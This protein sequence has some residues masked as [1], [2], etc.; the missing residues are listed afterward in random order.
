MQSGT[1]LLRQVHPQWIKDGRILSLAFR[2]F[3]K[4]EGLL[5]VYDGDRITARDSWLHFTQGQGFNSAGVWAVSVAESEACDLSSRPD[6]LPGNPDHAVIDFTAHARK[7]QEAKSKI[8]SAR[9]QERGCL[10]GP[11]GQGA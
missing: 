6:P 3:P 8:L 7:Q 11:D 1:L 9:A 5:S 10:F 4:D 2:P